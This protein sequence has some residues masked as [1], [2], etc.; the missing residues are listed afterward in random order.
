MISYLSYDQCTEL[1]L[2]TVRQA[3]SEID[4]APLCFFVFVDGLIPH[5]LPTTDQMN[6]FRQ[7][8]YSC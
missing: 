4:H 6:V 5:S 8:I 3:R 1:E 2:L 7:N